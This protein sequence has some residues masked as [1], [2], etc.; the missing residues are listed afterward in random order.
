VSLSDH[1]P[2]GLTGQLTIRTRGESGPGEVCV[3]I[4]GGRETFIAFS[5]SA[6]PVGATVL[7]VE[8]LR[9]RAVTVV[10]WTEVP[11]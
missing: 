7:I 6:I 8:S 10:P 4:R 1:D 3:R 2:V 11:A 5:D 9:N